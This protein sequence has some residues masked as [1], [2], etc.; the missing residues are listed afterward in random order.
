LALQLL[1]EGVVLA[2]AGGLVGILIAAWGGHL[3]VVAVAPT[4][5]LNLTM[6]PLVLGFTVAVSLA[7]GVLFSLAPALRSRRLDLASALKERSQA[8]VGSRRLGLAPALVTGQV[9][10]CLVLLVGAGLLTRSL[11]NL[12]GQDVGFDRSGLLLARLQTRLAGYRP[13]ELEGLYRRLIDQVRTI[14]GVTG[15]TVATYSP[16]GNMSRSNSIA[17]E[18]YQPRDG[19][20]MSSSVNLVGPHYPETMGVSL[21]AGRAFDDGDRP[22][23]PRVAMVNEAFVRAYFPGQTPVGRRLGFGEGPSGASEFEIVGVL[24]DAHFGGADEAPGK[25][26]YL[27]ILQTIDQ[28]AYTSELAIRINGDP[29]AAGPAVRAAI[30]TVDSRLP[31]SQMTTIGEQLGNALQQQRLF[32]RLVGVF[33]VLAVLLACVGL[34]GVVAQSVARRA[35]EVGIRMALGAQRGAILRMV[36]QETLTL[37]GAGLLI[38]IPAALA[39]A[40][41]IRGRLFGVGTADPLT[42]GGTSLLL[43]AVATVAGFIPARRAASVAPMAA[44]GRE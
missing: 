10:L 22:D 32:A 37:I 8:G 18:S 4:T 14:P 39:A 26:I 36:L 23:S 2:L 15:A 6:S 35:N 25:M 34:Y 43:I 16:M 5:P 29:A 24:G 11:V 38:G 41:L 33:G 20:D 44:L 42:I 13:A 31:I 9:A 7:A 40:Q 3:L 28:S 30:A 27:P 17:V 12:Q 21:Q 1:T 19:D